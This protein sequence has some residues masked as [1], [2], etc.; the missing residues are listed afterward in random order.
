MG[1]GRTFQI[2]NLFQEL[3]LGENVM[4]ALGPKVFGLNHFKRA[5]S[6]SSSA[7]ALLE[8][9]GLGDKWKTKIKN[10]SYGEQREVEVVLG[11]ALKS[12]VLLLDE[13]FAGLSPGETSQ[14]MDLIKRIRER[15]TIVLVEHDFD[16]VFELSDR[17]TVMHAGEVISIGTREEIRLDPVVQNAYLGGI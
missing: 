10:I 15:V 6:N 9:F 12:K 5:P 1:I 17:I 16:A 11:L 8:Q 7:L 4:L 3:T 2:T 14:M 13:P